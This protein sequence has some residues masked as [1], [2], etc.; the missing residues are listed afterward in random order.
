MTGIYL[1][2]KQ[3]QPSAVGLYNHLDFMG[4]RNLGDPLKFHA[5]V[6][7]SKQPFDAWMLDYP[8]EEFTGIIKEWTIFKSDYDDDSSEN[9]LVALLESETLNRLHRESLARGAIH[10]F[11]S[12]NPHIT[13][14]YKYR[15]NLNLKTLPVDYLVRF[16]PVPTIEPLLYY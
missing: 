9:C 14:S 4:V 2:M 16:N 7:I 12:Y 15:Q 8:K 3:S 5:T 6:S 11:D 1:A 13:V 10:P